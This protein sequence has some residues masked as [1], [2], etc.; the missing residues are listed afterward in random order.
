MSA[1]T[2]TVFTRLCVSAWGRLRM[3]TGRKMD[4]EPAAARVQ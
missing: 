4:Q 1:Y 2:P 3:S